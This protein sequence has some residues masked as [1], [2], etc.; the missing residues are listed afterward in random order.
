MI[1]NLFNN[2]DSLKKWKRFK[3]NILAATSAWIMIIALFFSFTAEFWAN[4][5]P[6]VLKFNHK[7]YL[8]IFYVR[9]GP[10]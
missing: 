1:E 9:L 10:A 4:S 6:V 3:S 2:Q 7:T 8:P 5:K